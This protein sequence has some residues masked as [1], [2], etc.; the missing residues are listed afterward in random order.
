MK[1]IV[2]WTGHDDND[3][4]CEALGRVPTVRALP[5]K[6]ASEAQA[7]M[8]RADVLIMNNMRWNADFARV[9]ASA[10]RL[11]WIQVLNAGFDNMERLGVPDR[12]V[13]STIGDI[14]STV[15]AEHAMALLLALV[16]RVPQSLSAQHRSEWKRAIAP[17][18]T[19][20]DMNVAVLGYG[21]VGQRVVSLLQ[22]FGARPLVVASAERRTQNGM[23][24]RALDSL[25]LVLGQASALVICAPLNEATRKVVNQAA[26]AAMRAGSYLVNVSRGGIV[27]TDAVVAALESGALAGAAMDVTDPEP[28]PAAHP[29]W[30]HPNVLLTPHVASSG[31]TDAE[32]TRLREFLVEQVRRFVNGDEVLYR[33]RLK[34]S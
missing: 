5:A 28:L 32:R 17:T 7:L 27:D 25:Q 15:V 14:A 24:V 13:V 33:A 31:T 19:L 10:P 18:E 8:L 26:F 20:G 30:Q 22:A 21:H 34:R 2:V 12:V 23:H 4:L 3:A 16:R 6:D 11:T 29:L 9:L 1:D